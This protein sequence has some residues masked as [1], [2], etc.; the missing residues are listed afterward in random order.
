MRVYVIVLFAVFLASCAPNRSTSSIERPT[1]KPATSATGDAR[2]NAFLKVAIHDEAERGEVMRTMAESNVS[3]EDFIET[4]F[5]HRVAFDTTP[6]NSMALAQL[7]EYLE[8]VRPTIAPAL[9][10]RLEEFLGVEDNRT[11][12]R[13]LFLQTLKGRN[14]PR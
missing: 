3:F 13:E 14:A 6:D 11:M 5:T 1:S 7:G 9:V 8:E 4:V 10:S 12:L 2:L